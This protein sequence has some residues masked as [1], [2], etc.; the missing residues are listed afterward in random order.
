MAAKKDE[1]KAFDVVDPS[2]SKLNI[3][4][5]PMVIGHKSASDTTLASKKDQQT[6]SA[7]E[8]VAP[9]KESAPSKKIRIEPLEEETSKNVA[10]LAES[11]TESV[12]EESE[13][14]ETDTSLNDEQERD[15]VAQAEN[16]EKSVQDAESEREEK[17]EELK[18]SRKY[19]VTIHEKHESA[20]GKVA[21]I[22]FAI[23]VSFIGVY[24]LADAGV[25]PGGEL[26]PFR[27]IGN[28]ESQ[29]E[30]E[31]KEVNQSNGVENKQAESTEEDGSEEGDDGL[32]ELTFTVTQAD[33]DTN[34][35]TFTNPNM[36]FE[37]PESYGT[38]TRGDAGV[39]GKEYF[40][41]EENSDYFFTLN[42]KDRVGPTGHDSPTLNLQAY[43]V[44]NDEV[45]ILYLDLESTTKSAIEGASVL[46]TGENYAIF[47]TAG[48]AYVFAGISMIPNDATYESV[49]FD[50]GLGSEEDAFTAEDTEVLEL[51]AILDTLSY[52]E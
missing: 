4:S 25:I 51:K 27:I 13:K 44:S 46:L 36:S 47:E 32:S 17:I 23:V 40:Y 37:Y 20:F 24:A 41:F 11:K 48:I 52:Q 49:V 19:F 30:V 3:G 5:K 34:L 39:P 21:A 28:S 12:P 18:K 14:T 2:E 9:E 7:D 6:Q 42:T 15:V 10:E 16:E 1:S 8:E 29:N 43:T 50:Y 31:S 35:V 38:I 26:L 33:D 45:S 22:V